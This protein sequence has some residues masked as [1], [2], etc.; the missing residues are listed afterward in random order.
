MQEN[1]LLPNFFIPG[2]AKSGTT[3]LHDLLNMH[4]EICMSTIKEPVYWNN[5]DYILPERIEWYNGLFTNKD[6]T[7]LGESTTSYMF[8][9]LFI[10]NIKK[11]YKKDPK[12]IFILRNPINRCYSHYWW[13]I[14]RGQEKLSFKESMDFDMKREFKEYDYIPNYYYHFGLYYKWLSR[15]YNSFDSKNIK[16]ITTES[17]ISNRH[18]TINDCFRFLNLSELDSIPNVVSNKTVKIKHPKAHHFIKKTASGKYRFTKIAKYF[19]SKN[20]I[21]SIKNKLKKLKFL[22]KSEPF[23]Y[24]KISEDDRKWLKELYSNDVIKLK[25][26]TNLSFKEWTDFNNKM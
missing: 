16:I 14:G 24:P 26:L 13:M 9:P 22:S 23:G 18:K 5:N 25:E 3:S 4:P 12:F 17:L 10:N 11:H 19:I 20:T 21:K 7:I 6:A 15:F 1:T 8:F 2:A